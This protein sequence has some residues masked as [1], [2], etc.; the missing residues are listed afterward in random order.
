MFTGMLFVY[1]LLPF[2]APVLKQAGLDGPAQLI[3][4]PYK[5][6]CHTYGFR[7]MYLF[8]PQFVYTRE[9]FDAQTGLNTLANRGLNGDVLAART[10]QGNSQMG[11]KVALCERDV[12]LYFSMGIGGIVFGLSRRRLRMMPWW[13]F[14]LIGVLPIGLD[15]F[16]Q[17]LSQFPGSPVP[18]RESTVTLRLLTGSMFGFSVAWL[19]FPI[20]HSTFEK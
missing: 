15:G 10:F 7:S 20:I 19:V 17:L 18:F 9:E 3:Y 1:S 11:Y 2:A 13:L 12:G 4:Q 8:G 6:M 14:V 16:S 5:L